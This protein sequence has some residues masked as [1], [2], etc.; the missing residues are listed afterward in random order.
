MILFWVL[1]G[2]LCGSLPFSVWLGRLFLRRD[3]R[4]GGAD[5]NPGAANAWRA[6][7]WRVGLPVLLLD[8]LK[9]AVPVS[10]A[11][12]ASGINGWAMVPV[13]LAPVLGHAYSPFLGFKGGKA[14][15]VTLGIWTGLAVSVSRPDIPFALGLLGG[16]PYALLATEGWPVLI[17]MI[18]FGGYLWLTGAGL[19]LLVIALLNLLI[20]VWKHR[21][22]LRVPPRLRSFAPRARGSAP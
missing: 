10:L 17:G 13:A 5:R 21:G 8:F 16:I 18:L 6:G 20:L 9:G 2:F 14:L 11:N 3:V 1:A 19:P 7:G 22:A 15:A 12:I 4:E